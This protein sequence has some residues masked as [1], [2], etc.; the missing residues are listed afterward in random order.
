MK[1]ILAYTCVV[2]ALLSSCGSG[3]KSSEQI[4]T[5]SLNS[6]VI[7][8]DD[9]LRKPISMA[10]GDDKLYV[11]NWS[12]AVDTL[13]DE[14]TL[15]GKFVRS[16]LTKGQGPGE[17]VSV[18]KIFY[19]SVNNS[20]VVND[21]MIRGKLVEIKQLSSEKPMAETVIEL[22][23]EDNDSVSPTDFIAPLSNKM[24]VAGNRP[25]EGMLAIYDAEGKFVRLDQPYP[26]KSVVGSELPD[27]CMSTFFKMWGNCSPDG[28]H[29]VAYS[30][31]NILVI[32]DAEKQ[33]VKTAS[34]VGDFVNGIVAENYG[35]NVAFTHSDR[36][37]I[38]FPMG[39]TTSNTHFYAQCSGLDTELNR[40]W[41]K[42]L[43]GEIE[44][45][46]YVRVY[47]FDGNIVK[48]LKLNVGKCSLAVS[49]D[50]SA[51]YAF[52]ETDEGYTIHKFSLK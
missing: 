38:Y 14:F 9:A 23:K 12:G 24:Y 42:M 7:I 39:I 5:L 41:Q 19:N 29:F 2:S 35:N 48:I 8:N 21:Y 37:H 32:G 11:L 20:L 16:F 44:P 36:Y 10:V 50:D 45:E 27:W 18:E 52:T 34:I 6:K 22:Q 46:C 33:S 49:P 1:K 25:L 31:A 28:K 3:E 40:Q 30:N 13:I 47:D 15:D 26:D 17:L 51:L 4:D 43:E